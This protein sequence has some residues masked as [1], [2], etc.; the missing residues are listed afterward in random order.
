MPHSSAM[1]NGTIYNW[2]KLIISRI[3]LKIRVK[4]NDDI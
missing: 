3:V 2:T 4:L 1:Q